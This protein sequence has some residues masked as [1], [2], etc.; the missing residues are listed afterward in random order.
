MIFFIKILVFLLQ[1]RLKLFPSFFGQL[2]NILAIFNRI[3]VKIDP[4]TIFFWL[5]ISLNIIQQDFLVFLRGYDPINKR[6][7]SCKILKEIWR[8]NLHKEFEWETFLL[9]NGVLLGSRCF[10][11]QK[12]IKAMW[13]SQWSRTKGLVFWI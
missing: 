6:N 3:L 10:S 9:K 4:D 5:I 7:W 12:D 8:E 2:W 11:I 1:T 13:K